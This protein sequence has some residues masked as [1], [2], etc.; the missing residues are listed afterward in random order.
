MG[1]KEKF[2]GI[3]PPLMMPMKEDHLHLDEEA[4][5]AMI[6]HVIDNGCTGVFAVSSSGEAMHNGRPAW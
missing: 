5:V 4:C 2:H 6:N 1:N 3:I